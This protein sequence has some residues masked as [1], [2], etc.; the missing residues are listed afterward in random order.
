MNQKKEISYRYAVDFLTV[1]CIF[2]K[3][4]QKENKV[5]ALT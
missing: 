4:T 5:Q 3:L 2:N 1:L